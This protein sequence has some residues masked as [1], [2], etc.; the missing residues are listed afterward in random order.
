MPARVIQH[1]RPIL[2]VLRTRASVGKKINVLSL[3]LSLETGG[4]GTA[5][6][7]KSA[8]ESV[9]VWLKCIVTSRERGS[10]T[11]DYCETIILVGDV[12]TPCSTSA[13][14]GQTFHRCNARFRMEF[15]QSVFSLVE[16][17]E[18][19]A[20]GGVLVLNI[21]GKLASGERW[22]NTLDQGCYKSGRTRVRISVLGWTR[23]TFPS[24]LGLDL[25]F[26]LAGLVMMRK[27]NVVLGVSLMNLRTLV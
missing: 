14:Y 21:K 26:H 20:K 11:W 19:V 5:T 4:D 24:G 12:Y 7:L 3:K 27:L 25:D 10:I 1:V 22:S 16:L 2:V 13:L 18:S 9:A 8:C 17:S 15:V 6:L 23:A